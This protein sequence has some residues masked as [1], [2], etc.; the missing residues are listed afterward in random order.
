M[1]RLIILILLSAM[2]YSVS[3]MDIEDQIIKI[4]NASDD[5]RYKLVN[6]LKRELSKLSRNER[7]NAIA[8][9]K[10]QM[11]STVNKKG[12]DMSVLARR[13]NSE[14]EQSKQ[15][16]QH[17]ILEQYPNIV[18]ADNT[19]PDATTQVTPQRP[20]PHK[21][22]EV[23]NNATVNMPKKDAP[24]HIIKVSSNTRMLS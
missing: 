5:N 3:A 15:N 13:C 9:L 4:R 17:N 16:G 24:A 2:T 12:S 8:A 20:R 21:A 22:V 19:K 18:S 14:V 23:I 10:Q 1:V 6:E 7:I 11:G